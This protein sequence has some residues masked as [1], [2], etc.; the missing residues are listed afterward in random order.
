MLVTYFL[1]SLHEQL[2]GFQV[3][4]AFLKVSVSFLEALEPRSFGP[5]Y[6]MVSV[7]LNTDFNRGLLNSDY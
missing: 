3:L 4:M 7:P 5:K 1:H 6:Q 2:D